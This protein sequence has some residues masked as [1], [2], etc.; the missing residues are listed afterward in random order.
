MKNK[1]ERKLKEDFHRITSRHVARCLTGLEEMEL[2]EI[3]KKSI[4][5]DLW[6]LSN[7]LQDRVMKE[8]ID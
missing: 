7:D 3:L 4:K 2:P 8:K 5:S 6:Y 1:K